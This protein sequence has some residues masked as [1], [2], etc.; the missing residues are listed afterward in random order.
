MEKQKKNSENKWKYG[1][2]EENSPLQITDGF[3]NIYINQLA[4]ESNEC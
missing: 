4:L 1:K 2:S 3:N